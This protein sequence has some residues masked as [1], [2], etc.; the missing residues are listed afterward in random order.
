MKLEVRGLTKR[1][2]NKYAL[3][4]VSFTLSNGVYGL[5]GPNG[6]GKTTLINIIVGVL[7][8][9]SGEVII[10]GKKVPQDNKNYGD[11]IG[12]LPQSPRLYKDFTA[13]E[14]MLYMCAL[15]N[16]PCGKRKKISEE[17]LKFVNLYE[18]KDKKIGTFS[19]G[20]KQRAGIAQALINDPQLLI[21]DEPTAGL[22]PKERIRFR[23]IISK[24]SSDRIVIYA[25][26]IVSDIESVANEILLLKDGQIIDKKETLCLIE[27]LKNKVWQGTV[28]KETLNECLVRYKVSNI[29]N[30]NGLYKIK[31]VSDTCPL[32]MESTEPTL[33]DVYL[34]YFGDEQ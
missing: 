8:P 29:Y 22:D 12:F 19:G 30:L 25:T 1:Y 31:I 24:L 34:Y 16:I 28:N 11:L 21:L 4:N 26:H 20:M 6:A 3:N 15:K 9:T 27:N 10:D 5:L 32:N 33:E 2:K 13:M 7:K 14:F 23:N 17:L 18:D